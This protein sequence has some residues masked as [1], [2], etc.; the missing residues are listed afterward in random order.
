MRIGYVYPTR[1]PV[2]RRTTLALM[3]AWGVMLL[4][5]IWWMPAPPRALV[6][7]SLIFPVYYMVLSFALHARRAR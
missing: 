6:L 4:A 2:L 7:A 3:A 5:I 1:T